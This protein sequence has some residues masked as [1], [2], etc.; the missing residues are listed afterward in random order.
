MKKKKIKVIVILLILFIV[1]I[2]S[3]VYGYSYHSYQ[4]DLKHAEKLLGDEKYDESVAAFASLKSSKFSKGDSAFIDSKVKLASE[5]KQSKKAFDVA[6]KLLD[7]KKY[8]DAINQFK[9]VKESD[10]KRYVQAQEKTKQANNLYITDNITKAKAEADNKRYNKAIEFLDVV[11]KFDPNNKEATTLKDT[12]TKEIQRIKEEEAKKQEAAKISQKKSTNTSNITTVPSNNS[13][14]IVTFSDGWFKVKSNSGQPVSLG[15]GMRILH[16]G[17]GGMDYDFLG[18][19]VQYEITFH[20]PKGDVKCKG[21]SSSEMKF[22]SG[23]GTD[24]WINI[25]ISAIYKGKTY[26]GSFYRVI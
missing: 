1:V 26:T 8:I 24:E 15:F 10:K 22:I 21:V 3:T 25:E 14:E 5:L 12:Y 23:S 4:T 11:L 7:E 6:M 18:D 13:E 20:F 2:A 16:K 19:N 17:L 9:N